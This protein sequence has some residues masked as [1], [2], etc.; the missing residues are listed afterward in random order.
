MYSLM[1]PQ[2]IAAPE[3]SLGTGL[4]GDDGGT[5]W[6]RGRGMVVNCRYRPSSTAIETET[7]Y[8]R[9]R[10]VAADW[11]PA[12][13]AAFSGGGRP[14]DRRAARQTAEDLRPGQFVVVRDATI[15]EIE[16]TPSLLISN[17][18]IVDVS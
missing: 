14:D 15:A 8:G 13:D 10:S 16:R 18:P 9:L 12:S 4:T 6:P 11:N 1:C 7:R 17:H 3:L 5:V 2:L